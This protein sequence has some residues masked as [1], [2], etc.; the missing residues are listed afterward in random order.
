M[1]SAA[2]EPGDRRPPGRIALTPLA[3][4]LLA[5]ALGLCAGYLDV[6]IIVVKKLC[7]NPEGH[8][9]IARD[10]PWSVPVGH[11]VLLAVPGV[12]LAAVSRLRPWARVAACG[13]V[14]AGDA[15]DLVGTVEAADLRRVQPA[16]GRRARPAD[17]RRGRGPRP[18]LAADAAW[19]RGAARR[20]GPLGG[21]LL[22]PGGTPRTPGGGRVAG[23][24]PRV[25]E[26][27]ADRLGHGP[28][29]QPGPLRISPGHDPQPC[30]VGATGRRLPTRPWRRRPGRIPRTVASSPASGRSRSIPSGIR[31]STPRP[32][33]WPS[34]WPHAGYQTAGFV[35]NTNSCT[36]ES[37]LD[38]GFAHFEDY[39]TDAAV[40]PGPDGPREV[41]R[42][43]GRWGSSAP[44]TPRSGSRFSP[45]MRARSTAR[46]ST[47]WA[48]GGPIGRSSPS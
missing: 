40:P 43:P 42:H 23:A 48:G 26:R 29:L 12:L 19:P 38:R 46:S 21:R 39:A 36:Y 35:A 32:R 24:P 10:F 2:L 28:R 17:R 11:A 37:G 18:G 16:A 30:P 13:L 8:Y 34:T 31:R 20:P 3:S 47:G 44:T 7:W 9:R 27:G 5:V 33:P 45:A 22:G 14:A 1:N 25:P 41:D 6:V 15:G 4:I